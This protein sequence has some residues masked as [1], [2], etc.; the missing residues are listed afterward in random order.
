[1]R[2]V[3]VKNPPANAGD[4]GLTLGCEDPLEK[5]MATHSRVLAWRVPWT[6][7]PGGLYSPWGR[8]E[9]DTTEQLSPHWAVCLPFELYLTITFPP[10]STWLLPRGTA[11]WR[12]PKQRS[13][14]IELTGCPEWLLPMVGKHTAL[15]TH[16]DSW[17]TPEQGA[18]SFPEAD[19]HRRHQSPQAE[20]A[21]QPHQVKSP[22]L[23]EIQ[24]DRLAGEC[25]QTGIYLTHITGL[26]SIHKY[27]SPPYGVFFP[28]VCVSWWNSHPAFP[29]VSMDSLV[30]LG[31]PVYSGVTSRPGFHASSGLT[32]TQLSQPHNTQNPKQLSLL[33]L[34]QT[35]LPPQ[36]KALSR[37]RLFVTPWT[38]Q[39][40][41]FSRPEYCHG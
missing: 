7:E 16:P 14:D 22:L 12:R 37:V 5:G 41:G 35:S 30:L 2:A 17:Q 29:S 28:Q 32:L 11:L 20:R 25:S 21:V 1:M 9:S 34:C 27:P 15:S 38:L 13:V 8:R 31:N 6:E 40:M 39:S 24:V 26:T 10:Q 4:T 36:R 33:H 19:S 3:V 18:P 23:S